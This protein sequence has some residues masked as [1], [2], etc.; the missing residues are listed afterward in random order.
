MYN[1]SIAM[2][3]EGKL[4]NT[5]RELQIK[6]MALLCCNFTRLEKQWSFNGLFR[7]YSQGCTILEAELC[8]ETSL[9]KQEEE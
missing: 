3:I 8:R 7:I 4:A 5:G 6:Y 2:F 9:L 1:S